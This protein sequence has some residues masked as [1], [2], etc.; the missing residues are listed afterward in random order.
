MLCRNTLNESESGL[1]KH[2]EG[3][4][5]QQPKGQAGG[6]PCP[7]HVTPEASRGE[8]EVNPE[9]T[10]RLTKTEALELLAQALKQQQLL[11]AYRHLVE[12]VNQLIKARGEEAIT[13]DALLRRL[14]TL[15]NVIIIAEKE[16]AK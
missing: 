11:Y 5:A 15:S 4:P 2:A 14:I 1:E 10:D 13:D 6:A 8:T 3:S 9:R 12:E 16:S 7:Q